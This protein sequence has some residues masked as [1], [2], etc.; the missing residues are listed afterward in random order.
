[1][2]SPGLQGNGIKMD[3]PWLGETLCGIPQNTCQHR[4]NTPI[5]PE[6]ANSIWHWYPA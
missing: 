5:Q 3:T 2:R 6:L 4:K 1:M